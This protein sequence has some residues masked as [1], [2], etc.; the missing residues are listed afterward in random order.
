MTMSARLGKLEQAAKTATCHGCG[1]PLVEPPREDRAA[2]LAALVALM[3]PDEL[4]AILPPLVKA[5]RRVLLEADPDSPA[6]ELA[7]V[8]RIFA[9]SELSTK[10]LYDLFPEGY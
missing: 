1:R 10:Q 6:R 2:R 4:R 3:T 8:I 9:T 5:M 7:K